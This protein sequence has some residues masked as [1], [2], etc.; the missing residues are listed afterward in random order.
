MYCN[1]LMKINIYIDDCTETVNVEPTDTV[2]TH[3]GA[4]DTK[5]TNVPMN[6]MSNTISKEEWIKH[7]Q[8]RLK[9]KL[10][11]CNQLKRKLHRKDTNF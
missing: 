4:P 3:V 6:T 10:R 9:T 1:L 7:L 11:L 8:K 2:T 5:S